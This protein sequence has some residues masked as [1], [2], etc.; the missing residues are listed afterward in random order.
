MK[1][2]ALTIFVA[3]SFFAF[4]SEEDIATLIPRQRTKIAA[5]DL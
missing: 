1:K 3:L 2:S 4:N 5:L